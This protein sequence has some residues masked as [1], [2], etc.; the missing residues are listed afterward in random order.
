MTRPA[1]SQLKLTWQNIG[2][3][4]D[5][6]N[7]ECELTLTNHSATALSGNDWA[8]YFSFCRKVHPD[9]VTGGVGI[10]HING[11]LWQL[12][13]TADFGTLEPGASRKITYRGMF[14]V[15]QNT[16][17]PLGFY[18]VYD[19][20]TPAA[21]ASAIGDPEIIAF[22]RPEQRNRNLNDKVTPVTAASRFDDN[23]MLSL[24]PTAQTGLITPKP[25][26]LTKG[27]GEFL[28]DA[29]T[30][31]VHSMIWPPKPPFCNK[32]WLTWACVRHAP[33]P[34]RALRCRLARLKSKATPARRKKLSPGSDQR[35]HQHYR[36]QRCRCV[37]W[38][39][40]PAPVAAGQC[41]G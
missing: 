2:N 30:L 31:I 40:K 9:S 4:V 26:S 20:G 25:L 28:I 18:I 21:H 13:P 6:D 39:S 36:R 15:I 3:H 38:H 23:A 17:A 5:G 16:D 37:Q 10:K 33:R 41:L 27:H 11:D 24:L 12:T 34:V 19:D 7:F 1:G 8:I 32:A 35:W 22:T 29:A 14:W